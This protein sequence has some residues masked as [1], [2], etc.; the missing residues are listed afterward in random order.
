VLKDELA[1]VPQWEPAAE[2]AKA[3]ESTFGFSKVV[4]QNAEEMSVGIPSV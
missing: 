2:A 4:D 1:F 3:R